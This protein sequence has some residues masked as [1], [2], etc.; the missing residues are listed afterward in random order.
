[1]LM[2]WLYSEAGGKVSRLLDPYLAKLENLA[3]T[4]LILKMFV[5]IKLNLT[6]LLL[7]TL[8]QCQKG[9]PKTYENNRDK[10]PKNGDFFVFY[11]SPHPPNPHEGRCLT[12]VNRV[13]IFRLSIPRPPISSESI[14]AG[15][16]I[17]VLT[18]QSTR[19]ARHIAAE[20]TVSYRLCSRQLIWICSR[21]RCYYGQSSSAYW[22]YE[23]CKSVHCWHRHSPNIA[24]ADL[25]PNAVALIMTRR[26]L[27]WRLY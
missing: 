19:V 5:P 2:W 10:N 17:E 3:M 25:C 8:I 18:L 21:Y 27:D 20:W 13:L 1:M 14:R 23:C 26:L 16:D 4:F 7:C 6:L 12:A 15:T 9:P 22:S 11:P 24:I